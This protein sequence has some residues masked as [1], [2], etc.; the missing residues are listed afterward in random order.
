MNWQ[1]ARD[2]VSGYQ[3]INNEVTIVYQ[4]FI[5]GSLHLGPLYF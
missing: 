2:L 4:G 5:A 3:Y 1:E